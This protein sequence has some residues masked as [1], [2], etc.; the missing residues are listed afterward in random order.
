MFST[1]AFGQRESEPLILNVLNLIM[2]ASLDKAE[3]DIEGFGG[4]HFA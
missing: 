4:L 3:L 1:K 2:E